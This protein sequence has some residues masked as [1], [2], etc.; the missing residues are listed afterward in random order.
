MPY[1]KCKDPKIIKAK[2]SCKCKGCSAQ[3]KKGELLY[4]WPIG[5]KAYCATCGEPY[6]RDFISSAQDEMFYHGQYSYSSQF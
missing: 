5:K 4:Y 2:F 6:Y 3:I 1:F